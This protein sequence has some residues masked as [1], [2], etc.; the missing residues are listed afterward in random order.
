MAE[1]EVTI[2]GAPM[3]E[4]TSE[5]ETEE[6]PLVPCI[7]MTL[8]RG[9]TIISVTPILVQRGAELIAEGADLV[10]DIDPMNYE[11]IGK[12]DEIK[13]YLEGAQNAIQ[14]AAESAGIL[15]DAFISL[16]QAGDA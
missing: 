15:V 16:A 7:K 12:I 1:A 9:Q 3:E 10:A 4:G 6:H 2:A 5:G 11:L 8:E 13:I 14:K